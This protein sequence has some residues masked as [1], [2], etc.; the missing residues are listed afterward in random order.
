MWLALKRTVCFLRRVGN[1]S[2]RAA[3]DAASRN[4]FAYR[5]AP[6]KLRWMRSLLNRVAQSRHIP[7][8]FQGNI[9]PGWPLQQGTHD[10]STAKCVNS[11]KCV[12]AAK[13]VNSVKCVNSTLNVLKVGPLNVSNTSCCVYSLTRVDLDSHKRSEG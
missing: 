5:L 10:C 13:C 8:C 6:F 11:A 1:H 4:E 7:P 2:R 9:S 3:K 12:N